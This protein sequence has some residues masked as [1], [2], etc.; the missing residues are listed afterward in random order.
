METSDYEDGQQTSGDLLFISIVVIVIKM[1]RHFNFVS[2][3]VIQKLG[4]PHVGLLV[5]GCKIWPD[6]L[7]NDTADSNGLLQELSW[8][9]VQ[10]N[11]PRLFL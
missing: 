3:V 5:H 9:K 2:S 10:R 1:R 8:E 7:R 11:E 4:R 6:R